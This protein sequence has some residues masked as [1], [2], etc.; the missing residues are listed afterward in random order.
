MKKD[1]IDHFRNQRRLAADV[2]PRLVVNIFDCKL[3]RQ[4]RQSVWVDRILCEPWNSTRLRK[5]K[6]LLDLGKTPPDVELTAYK[7][8]GTSWYTVSDGI[9]RT[10]SYREAGRLKI[11]ARI[12]GCQNCQPERFRL[13]PH[14]AGI[15]L[16]CITQWYDGIA[17]ETL[18]RERFVDSN[19]VPLFKLVGV[20][21]ETALVG[22]NL[23]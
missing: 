22:F 8:L 18:T 5:A 14:S 13:V 11:T 21:Q 16:I 1:W 17:T 10:V 4:Q 7:L 12:S 19:L 9:H 20:K 15:S 2:L 3:Y 23:E 6:A